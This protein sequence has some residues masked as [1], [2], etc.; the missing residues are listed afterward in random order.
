[1]P[2]DTDENGVS[3]LSVSVHYYSPWSFCGDGNSGEYT[4]KDKEYTEQQLSSM[5]KYTDMGYGV[6]LGEYGVCNPRQDR[7]CDWLQDVMFYSSQYGILPV[8]WDSDGRYFN[9]TTNKMKYADV[10]ELYNRVTGASGDTSMKL[11]TG[12]PAVLDT[13][14]V[15]TLTSSWD[16]TG[17]WYKNSGDNMVGDDRSEKVT[18]DDE[19]KFVPASEATAK[20]ADDTTEI[21]FNLWGYYAFIKL[22]MSK[23][24][25]PAISFD[26]LVNDSDTVGKLKLG[27]ATEFTGSTWIDDESAY[28]NF[29]TKAVVLSDDMV[30]DLQTHPYLMVTF[31]NKPIVTG[32][33]IYETA[34]E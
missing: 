30:E 17:K 19:T 27:S 28:T 31:G 22:D 23:Y 18:E 2:T 14:D 12:T 7:V 16:W 34:T 33:H 10:G 26:F 5:K 11:R 8:L 15:S 25:K 9:R 32:I 1:M 20:D 21:T 6:I 29:T 3:K 24:K 13:V 4:E